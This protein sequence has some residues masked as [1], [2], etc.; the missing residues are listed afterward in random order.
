MAKILIVD[1]DQLMN[2]TLATV[3]VLR[4]HDVVCATTL[5]EGLEKAQADDLD[6]IF[7]DVR[8]PDG[9]GLKLLPMFKAAAAYPEI[10]IIT[11]YADLDGAELAIKNGAWDYIQKP[12]SVSGITLSLERALQYRQGRKSKNFP[13]V[14]KRDGIIGNSAGIN[15]VLEQIAQASSSDVNV[16]IVGETGTGKE[17]FAKAIHE[18]SKHKKGNFV[19]V[20]CTAIPESLVESI[21]FGHEKGAFT[22]ANISREGLI[23]QAD[24]GTLFLDEVGELPLSIQKTFLR[25][26][27]EHRFRPVGS[28]KE[29]ISDFRLIAAT[30]RDLDRMTDQ[31]MFRSDLLFRL[32]SFYIEIPPLRD[33]KEDIKDL[34]IYYT[35]MRCGFSGVETK[36]FSPDFIDFLNQYEWPGNIRELFNTLE[37]VLSVACYETTLCPYH[38]PTYIR[39]SVARSSVDLG[40]EQ[41]NFSGKDF[42]FNNVHSEALPTIEEMRNI[43][44]KIYLQKLMLT[45]KGNMKKACEI[46]GLSRT[47]L[48]ELRKKHK[49]SP[50]KDISHKKESDNAV[51]TKS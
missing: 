18:N 1:D 21:L 37:Q 7:L 47:R 27:Q 11:G 51:G 25:V 23:R 4:G 26:I 46:S 2:E 43:T 48:F 33:R 30:N 20:D 14:L 15:M 22:G 12:S 35:H 50:K 3:I 24:Q 16:L 44:E 34:V 8:M 9:D 39:A 45:A 17:L 28:K 32:R 40:V 13:V 41:K 29:I 38:L 36:G 31:N 5:E 19:V 42:I 6:V 10:I 49:I